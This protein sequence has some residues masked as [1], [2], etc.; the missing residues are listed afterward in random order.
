ML[1]GRFNCYGCGRK[2]NSDSG[3]KNSGASRGVIVAD[4][5]DNVENKIDSNACGEIG[6]DV[7]FTYSNKSSNEESSDD[8]KNSYSNY[9]DRYTL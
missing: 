1:K 3:K 8:G 9:G 2:N 5:V 6:T 4:N 7:E